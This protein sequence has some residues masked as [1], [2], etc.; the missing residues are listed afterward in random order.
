VLADSAD[1]PLRRTAS[2]VELDEVYGALNE[3]SVAL[4]PAGANRDGALSRLVDVGAANLAGNGATLGQTV[5]DLSRAVRTLADGR[6]DLAGVVRDLAV[7]TRALAANDR[8]V[9]QFNTLLGTVAGQLAGERTVLAA[10]VANLA[11]ALGEVA[12][13]V[14]DNRAALHADVAGLARLSGVLARQRAALAEVL[15]TA[16]LALGNL[17]NAYNASAGTLDTRNQLGSLA[18]PAV[19]CGLLDA[20][21]RLPRLDPAKRQLCLAL[22]GRLG[23]LPTI[24]G[25]PAPGQPGTPGVPGLPGLPAPRLPVPSVSVPSLPPVPRLPAPTTSA[26]G[27]P[28]PSL[29][30]PGPSIGGR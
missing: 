5:A 22:A 23:S 8:Q 30:L 24:P 21:G 13:F 7:F 9:R 15:D 6:D 16:P 18:S 20:L 1:I 14:R 10:A 3:L 19:L 26:S 4:G 25:A 2:P 12:T 29:P 28:A 11:T 17:N 27:L